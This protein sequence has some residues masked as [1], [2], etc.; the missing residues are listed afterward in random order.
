MATT[1]ERCSEAS[2]W[3]ATA[4]A[5]TIP[6]PAS[7]SYR[8]S[9]ARHPAT[10]QCSASDE[11][12]DDDDSVH[13]SGSDDDEPLEA[14]SFLDSVPQWPLHFLGILVLCVCNVTIVET[15]MRAVMW[16]AGLFAHSC[17]NFYS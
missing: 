9:V 5:R 4:V 17:L 16:V 10:E 12:A 1:L 15:G 11:P 3:S 13:G 14:T 8:V 7:M 6:V 2:I